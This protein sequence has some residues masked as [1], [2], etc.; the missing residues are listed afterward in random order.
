MINKVILIGR[1]GQDP[2][3]RVSNNNVAVANL[4]L[5]TTNYSQNR[6]DTDW[7]RVVLFSK[8]AELAKQYLKKGSM[9]YI[10]GRIKYS[11]YT[12][13]E[14]I[15]IP[16]T[17]IIAD[18]MQFISSKSAEPQ[19]PAGNNNVSKPDIEDIPF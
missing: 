18:K 14:G 19:E 4:N 10:E 16:T 8:Q 13:K 7:H 3:C 1:L 5:A 9:V 17:D 6:E 15:K 11:S 12:N 2:E